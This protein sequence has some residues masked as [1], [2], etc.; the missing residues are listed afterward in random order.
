MAPYHLYFC[1][2]SWRSVVISSHVLS[3]TWRIR[4]SRAPHLC[5]CLQKKWFSKG[6]KK[7]THTQNISNHSASCCR[8]SFVCCSRVFDLLIRRR[9]R[10]GFCW[11]IRGVFHLLLKQQLADCGGWWQN[12]AAKCSFTLSQ[13]TLCVFSLLSARVT[14]IAFTSVDDVPRSRQKK[15]IVSPGWS[16]LMEIKITPG[17]K[18]VMSI[19]S[20]LRSKP[21]NENCQYVCMRA[22]RRRAL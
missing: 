19:G 13:L 1:P 12:N 6:G 22:Q 21:A 15:S 8:T 7:H 10:S 9:E 3:G 20:L 14:A 17:T 5:F 11:A 4:W 18:S 16:E 2:S